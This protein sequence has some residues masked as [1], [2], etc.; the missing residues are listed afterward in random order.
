LWA[1]YGESDAVYFNAAMSLNMA[2]AVLG[3]CNALEGDS[4]RG[5][6]GAHTDPYEKFVPG[7]NS[8]GGML[9]PIPAAPFDQ[10]KVNQW[11]ATL[12]RDHFAAP[13]RKGQKNSLK[14]L[15]GKK[16]PKLEPSLAKDKI[17]HFLLIGADPSQKYVVTAPFFGPHSKE[18][19]YPPP[20]VIIDYRE[21]FR[22]YRAG[23]YYWLQTL[24]D[25]KGADASAQKYGEL[26]KALE[27]RAEGK[28]FED[29]MKEI[30]GVQLSDK[31]GDTDSLEWRFLKWLDKGK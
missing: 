29:V 20:E 14:E 17:A 25:P 15:G 18:R 28:P 21:F 10:M 26:L 16:E 4:G 9:P 8:S 19:P 22:A 6:T 31:N 2:I 11:R 30:Y 3:E 23:F 13:L 12:G 24:G 27:T 7:G 1:C 5:T